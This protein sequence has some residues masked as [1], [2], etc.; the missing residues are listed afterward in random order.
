MEK[1]HRRLLLSSI[2]PGRVYLYTAALQSKIYGHGIPVVVE[3]TEQPG[4]LRGYVRLL[5]EGMASR[6]I[7]TSLVDG[8]HYRLNVNRVF[9]LPDGPFAFDEGVGR[10]LSELPQDY[11]N[12]MMA[13]ASEAVLNAQDEWNEA[14]RLFKKL[15]EHNAA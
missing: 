13:R 15:K 9:S 1:K 3:C 5:T 8:A 4:W 11:G 12:D 10:Y 7:I 6:A 14:D 2:V